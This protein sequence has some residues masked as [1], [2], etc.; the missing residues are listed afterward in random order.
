MTSISSP[1]KSA[2][3]SVAEI[4]VESEEE[5][6]TGTPAEEAL[7]DAVEMTDDSDEDADTGTPAEEALGDAVESREVSVAAMEGSGS[8]SGEEEVAKGTDVEAG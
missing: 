7:G 2:L 3:V 5:A 8:R 6:E 1:L 4:T